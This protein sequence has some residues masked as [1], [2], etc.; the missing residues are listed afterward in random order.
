MLLMP[1]LGVSAD[2]ADAGRIVATL[3][4]RVGCDA[5]DAGRSLCLAES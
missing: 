2:A 4:R 5:A 3:S 1:G